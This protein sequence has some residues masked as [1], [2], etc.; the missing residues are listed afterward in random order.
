MNDDYEEKWEA[1]SNKH[2]K[3]RFCDSMETFRNFCIVPL[4]KKV[5]WMEVVI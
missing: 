4:M 1:S 5:K 2:E 3:C